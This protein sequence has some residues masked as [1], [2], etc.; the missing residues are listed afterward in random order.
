MAGL[1]INID[2]DLNKFNRLVKRVNELKETLNE[3]GRSHPNFNKLLTELENTSNEMKRMKS[4][5]LSINTALAHIDL[6]Q[7]VVEDS[8]KIRKSTDEIGDSF[9]EYADSINGIKAQMK[10]LTQEFNRM[11]E[12]EKNGASGQANINK[13][14]ELN[15]QLKITSEGV[16]ALS[17]EYANNAI[18]SQAQEG[19]LKSL[20]AQLSNLRYEYDNISRDLRNGTTG[21]E[22]VAQIKKVNDEL[23]VAEQAT[24]RYQRNVGNYAS[25]WNGLNVQVQQVARELPSLAY[26]LNTFISAIGNNLPM[27]ADEIQ[28]ARKEYKSLIA[29]NK[30]ATPVWKQLI[31]S[32]FNWQTGLVAG[33]TVLALYNKE[34][35]EWTKSL[36][37]AKKT[38]SETYKTTEEFNKSVSVTSGNVI[39]TLEQ[40]SA[41]WKKL[42]GDIKAQEKY[43]LDYK[44]DFDRLGAAVNSVEEAEN[45]LIKGKAAFIESIIAKA[46]S[47]SIMKLASEEYVKYLQKMR[48]AE[49]M[50][51]G[52]TR[53]YW[54]YAGAA[55]GGFQ[56]VTF[57][58]KNKEKIATEEEAKKYLD[59]FNAM[60]DDVI[61]AEKDGTEKLKNAG[62]ELTNSLV[63]GS[64][65][66]IKAAI[67]Q[68]QQELEKV[69]DPK[70]YQRIEDEIKVMQA[71]LEAITGKSTKKENAVFDQK[72][73][74]LEIISK[75]ALERIE[76]EIELENQ[77]AQERINAMDEGFNKEQAQ[78]EFNNK[79]ELQALQRQKEEYIRSYIQTQKEIFEAKE[80]LKAKQNPN[81]KKQSFDSS[82]ISV[83]TSMFDVVEMLTI[84]RQSADLAK[85]YK[86]LLS[87]Y[88]DYTTKR[89]EIQK[90]FN[91]DRNALE[92][93]GASQERINELEYQ[94]KETLD[95]IDLE[96]AQREDSFQ[97]WMNH[98]ANLSLEKLRE[99]LMLAKEELQRQEL[100]NPNDPQLA[101][102]RAQ[103][104]TS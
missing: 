75:N 49:A 92:K 42:G 100:I 101:V 68:K 102:I 39:A 28:R 31:S 63:E 10:E 32:I 43:I 82:S 91:K 77:A 11:S 81:Y 69:V 7:K 96:F 104:T 16:R 90:K 54:N 44:D 84:K 22:L 25:A 23:N 52:R 55:N 13:W 51:E 37:N 66:A 26:G 80:D 50:P 34:I 98:I 2:F 60:I 35:I 30:K 5:L 9:R 48:E 6:S 87:T 86:D 70:E 4:E 71:K 46:K 97:A 18:I 103:V 89:L 94:R 74:L 1:K 14:A 12:A 20:R 27:L 38:L 19:S 61:E 95:A 40:L 99:M 53:S 67:T 45:I 88:Q 24:G 76:K 79:K 17:K 72:N 57:F 56:K 15:A 36:F 21:A 83:D 62:I 78:R 59:S 93:A 73:R 47:T 85:Y 3:L 58:E 41:G 33:I 65:G 29:E 8:K 64:V